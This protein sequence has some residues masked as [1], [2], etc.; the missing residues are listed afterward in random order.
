MRC[1]TELSEMSGIPSAK[2]RH[3][4]KKKKKSKWEAANVTN[5]QIHPLKATSEETFPT[6]TATVSS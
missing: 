5:V 3:Q 1:Q 4:K 6:E 2:W